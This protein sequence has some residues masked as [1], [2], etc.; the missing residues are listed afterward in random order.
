F[1]ID[2]AGLARG[3]DARVGAPGGGD[4]DAL[5]AEGGDGRLNSALDGRL[6]GL[7][8]KAV[9]G[10]AVVFNGEAVPGHYPWGP[11]SEGSAFS[12]RRGSARTTPA[13]TGKPRSISSAGCAAL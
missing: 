5:S 13:G 3:V 10:R 9:I 7:G 1:Q 6:V 4:A 12:T 11:R 8:L 2:M